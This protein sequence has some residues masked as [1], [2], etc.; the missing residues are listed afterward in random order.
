ML[1]LYAASFTEHRL[2]ITNE[3]GSIWKFLV[4]FNKIFYFIDAVKIYTT[5]L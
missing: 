1:E 2:N 3:F 4:Y 5:I